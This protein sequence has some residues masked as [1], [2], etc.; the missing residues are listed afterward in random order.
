M[1]P[2]SCARAR[3]RVNCENTRAFVQ[4]MDIRNWSGTAA[5]AEV[6]ASVRRGVGADCQYYAMIFHLDGFRTLG[7]CRELY[8]SGSKCYSL[9]KYCDSISFI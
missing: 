1:R 4:T 2:S 9:M 6:R 7:Y 5:L 8:D 3:A